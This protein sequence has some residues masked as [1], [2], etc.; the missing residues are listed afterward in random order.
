MCNM[1]NATLY[2]KTKQFARPVLA[3]LTP[4]QKLRD[5]LSD[6]TGEVYLPVCV[7]YCPF[8]GEPKGGEE[9]GTAAD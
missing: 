6:M 5:R 3:P 4:A 1:C 7:N 9:D 2:I 8:C